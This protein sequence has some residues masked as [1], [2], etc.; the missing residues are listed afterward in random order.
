MP[1]MKTSQLIQLFVVFGFIHRAPDDSFTDF[2]RKAQCTNI[3]RRMHTLQRM[4]IRALCFG[5]LWALPAQ[6]RAL[7]QND[8]W[9]GPV[10]PRTHARAIRDRSSRVRLFAFRFRFRSSRARGSGAR[11]G[12]PAPPLLPPTHPLCANSVFLRGPAQSPRD[13]GHPTATS[14]V[15]RVGGW[16]VGTKNQ[17]TNFSASGSTRPMDGADGRFARATRQYTPSIGRVLSL[18]KKLVG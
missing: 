1:V 8:G 16:G 4:H 14:M 6:V 3:P 17:P 10:V 15:G 9:V 18:A 13:Y 11:V 12:H 7:P 5:L 2:G